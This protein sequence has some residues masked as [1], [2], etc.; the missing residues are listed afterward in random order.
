MKSIFKVGDKV[1]HE[2]DKNKIYTVTDVL[3]QPVRNV[4]SFEG[5]EKNGY[6]D[7]IYFTKVK[8]PKVT[9][10]KVKKI[11]EDKMFNLSG[12]ID[13]GKLV[14]A[15]NEIHRRVVTKGEVIYITT[16]NGST[17]S[18]LKRH[19]TYGKGLGQA[20][21]EHKKISLLHEWVETEDFKLGEGKY[22][23]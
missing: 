11:P 2:S 12:L 17:A 19:K 15:F 23:E 4:L 5:Y 3:N 21:I 8:K 9:K 7:D 1:Y 14:D 22:S 16:D 10:R 18:V 20:I 6:F 13:S